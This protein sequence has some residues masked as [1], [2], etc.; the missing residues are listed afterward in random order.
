MLN[1]AIISLS[2]ATQ[3]DKN[4]RKEDKQYRLITESGKILLGG[5]TYSYRGASKQWE[6]LDGTWT[7]ENGNEENIYIE[8]V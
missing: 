5:E 8:E 6:S 4:M 3:E 1:S 2:N 7:D